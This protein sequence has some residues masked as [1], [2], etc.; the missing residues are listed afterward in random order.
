MGGYSRVTRICS[1]SPKTRP[2]ARLRPSHGAPVG[3][4]V[5]SESRRCSPGGRC[6]GHCKI[7]CPL[8]RVR[9]DGG[10]AHEDGVGVSGSDDA[11]ATNQD[12]PGGHFLEGRF[13][14]NQRVDYTVM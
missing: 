8:G 10:P 14:A 13:G 2:S 4:N 5:G 12:L 7:G 11:D 3:R 6:A 9:G 1:P